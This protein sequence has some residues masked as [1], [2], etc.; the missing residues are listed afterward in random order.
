VN[1]TPHAGARRL[2]RT[3]LAL[4]GATALA[5][6]LLATAP[7]A[8]AGGHHS[9]VRPGTPMTL[10][11]GFIS[12]LSLDIGSRGTA[13]LTQ[14]FTGQVTAVDRAGVAT[15]IAA[16][17]GLEASAVSSRKGTV[18]YAAVANDHSSA[19][20]MSL[21]PG[22]EPQ[23]FADIQAYEARVNPDR[24]NHYGF[25]NLPQAC[26]DQVPADAP[27]PAVYTGIVD[28]HPYASLATSR[29]LYLADAGA[30]AILRVGYNGRVSTVAVLPPGDP[31]AVSAELAEQ[32]GFPDCVVGY[33]YRFEPVPTD[34]E[35]GPD[36]WLYV[37]SLPGGAEDDSLGARGAVYKVN[38]YSGA[39]R[40]V[41]SGLVTATGL[42]V[43]PSGTIY[44][45][46]LFGG[47]DGTGQISV[48]KNGK[49]RPFLALGQPAAIELSGKKLYVTTDALAEGP[50]AK[51]TVVPLK[52]HRHW[53]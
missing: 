41:A 49:P 44:V 25:V 19:V 27:A 15:T 3:G 29:G 52:S 50:T 43:S 2:R 37:T 34:V 39:V 17:E 36:G 31:V 26:L 16:T 28:T 1:S 48:V 6:S 13:Y 22:A 51:L 46:E 53:R 42:A 8:S 38:P 9:P 32:A 7:A 47:A 14:N 21:K 4:V 12:P 33:N 35:L 45:A 24:V 5:A 20:M 18:Y 11:E 10:A 23:P 30:N 40:K